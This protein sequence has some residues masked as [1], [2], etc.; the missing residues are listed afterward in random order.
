MA[1]TKLFGSAYYSPNVQQ[2][3]SQLELHLQRFKSL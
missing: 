2:V 1:K 3:F